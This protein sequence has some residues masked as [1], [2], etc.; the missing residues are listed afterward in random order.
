MK[1]TSFSIGFAVSLVP[2][3]AFAAGPTD[4]ALACRY[5]GIGC[6]NTNA[7]AMA[8]PLIG[9]TLVAVAAGLSVLFVVVGGALMLISAGDEGQVQK[10]KMSIVYALVGLGIAL[11]SQSFTKFIA[12]QFGGLMGTSDPVFVFM[13][14]AVGAMVTIFNAVFVLMMVGAGFRMAFARGSSD[15]FTKARGMLI[16][17]V[18][19]AIVVNVAYSLVSAVMSLSL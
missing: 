8:V 18:A 19:G 11:V 3:I 16:W 13:G 12:M 4:V 14:L 10:G 6:T 1:L 15:E 17:A 5:V 7:L 2:S 9:N